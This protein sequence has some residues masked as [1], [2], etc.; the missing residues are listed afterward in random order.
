MAAVPAGYVLLRTQAPPMS[1]LSRL[2]PEPPK[3]TQGFGGWEEIE[4]PKRKSITRFAGRPPIVISLNLL[5]DGY[6][7]GV[8][9]EAECK[10]LEKM[11]TPLRPGVEPPLV[12]VEGAVPH[13]DLDFV[14]NGIQW[15]DMIRSLLGQRM[16]AEV[17]LE[18][19]EYVADDR[20]QFKKAAALARDDDA[21][22]RA[23]RAFRS[24]NQT[25]ASNRRTFS[26]RDG[27]TLEVIAARELGD[28]RLWSQIAELNDIRDPRT[29]KSGQTIILP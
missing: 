3:V 29:I 25:P 5:L 20:I 26:V 22:E 10:K 16:R 23:K 9:M 14:I 17:T 1:V 12:E 24:A 15:G 13:K 8:S 21:L 11:A 19:L 2:G 6:A 18:L 27:D 28:Y 7:A 4:R